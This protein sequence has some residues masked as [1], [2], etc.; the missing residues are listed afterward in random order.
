MNA[1][2]DKMAAMT[3]DLIAYAE[4]LEGQVADLQR[5]VSEMSKTASAAVPEES[6]ERVCSALVDAG[7]INGDQVFQTKKAFMEDPEAIYRVIPGVIEAQSKTA[8]AEV[9]DMNGGT[10]VGVRV[11]M[12]DPF[13]SSME[14]MQTLLGMI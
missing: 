2:L 5:Q 7:Y 11:K 3:N 1:E 4:K 14:R 13:A 12:D 9:P 8:A 6:I 10:L